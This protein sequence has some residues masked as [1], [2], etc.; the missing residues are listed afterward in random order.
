[1]TRAPAID[2]VRVFVG[3]DSAPTVDARVSLAMDELESLGPST[4]RCC[5]WP[6]P[7]APVTSTTSSPRRWSTSPAVTAPW[8]RCGTRCGRRSC[9]WIGS[10]WA[11]TRTGILLHAI[12]GRLRATPELSRPRL[13]ALGESLGALTLQDAFLHEGTA[14][15]H[16]A[17]I[18]RGL[19]I[20]TPAEASGRSSGGSRALAADPD[21]EVVEVASYAEWQELPRKS[22]NPPATCC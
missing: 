19:F 22:A 21:E 13:V 16:R 2:P 5:A 15:L 11:A 12:N 1:M 8:W 4:G 17:G 9:R 7:P 3:L 14:G 18:E 6:R 10:R 20:G